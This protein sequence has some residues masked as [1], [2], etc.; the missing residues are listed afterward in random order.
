MI[1]DSTV[2]FST[3]QQE[4]GFNQILNSAHI[5]FKFIDLFSLSVARDRQSD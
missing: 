1:R 4:V 2:E 3:Q 5:F